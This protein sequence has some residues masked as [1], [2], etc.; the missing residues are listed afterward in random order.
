MAISTTVCRDI[1]D[2][3]AVLNQHL[4]TLL[5]SDPGLDAEQ[6]KKLSAAFGS[7]IDTQLDSLIDRVAK[8]IERSA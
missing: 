4:T 6:C 8:T 7:H 2:T 1:L 5:V 3:R